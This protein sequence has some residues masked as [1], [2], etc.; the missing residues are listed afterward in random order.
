MSIETHDDP[1][2]TTAGAAKPITQGDSPHATAP[3]WRVGVWAGANVRRMRQAD[4]I[5]LGL[6]IVAF[7]YRLY[8]IAH[9]WPQL[10]SDEAVIG[11]M[12]RHILHGEYPVF[13]WGQNYMGAFQAYFAA[14]FF[15]VFGP[16]AFWLH[17]SVLLL[18]MGF[19]A[20]MYGLA[21][22]AY[23]RVVG[24]VMLLWLTVGPTMGVLRELKA[25]GGYQ[26]ILLFGALTLLG[27]WARLRQP[28]RMPRTRRDWLIALATYV[29]L[30]V[31]MGVGLW[32]DLLILPVLLLAVIALVV[33]RPR[34]VCS[35]LG[36]ALLLAFVIS[37]YPYISF[38]V[39]HPNA[40]YNQL[41]KMNHAP[42][43][44]GPIPPPHNWAMQTG[45]TLEVALP[46]ILGSP[47]VCVKSGNIW[48]DY[49]TTMAT[50]TQTAGGACDLTNMAFSLGALA[51]YVI[52]L[53]PI[54]LAL[55]RWA[56]TQLRLANGAAADGKRHAGD[57][58]LRRWGRLA[59]RATRANLVVAFARDSGEPTAEDHAR[60]ARLARDW[61]RLLLVGVGV[62]N[63]LAYTT[64]VE[65]Q[66]FQFT[67]A[68]YLLLVYL[69]AP[70][71]IGVL[72]GGA[73]P[74]ARWLAGWPQS[75][76]KSD[77][78]TRLSALPVL[79]RAHHNGR[80]SAWRMAWT[81]VAAV[82]LATLLALS[83]YGGAQTLAYTSDNAQFHA[84]MPV[85]D[86]QIIA[87]LDAHHI[88]AFYGDYWTCYRLAFE[89]NERAI[90]AVRGGDPPHTLDL[91]ANRY[92]PYVQTLAHTAHPAY[93]YLA[94]GQQDRNFDAYAAAQRL[95]HVGYQRVV[96]DD[97]AVYYYPA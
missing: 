32:S 81:A 23:G 7:G 28:Q 51:L 14:I 65:A 45:E 89:S 96:I 16:S 52:A 86:Q 56:A 27:V 73:L 62:A 37:A 95:P 60:A 74:V 17:F 12:A 21:S 42:G 83:L 24:V 85:E 43:Q 19:L 59:Y 15:A 70:I 69:S 92:A 39:V 90:C 13:F 82:G 33:G 1:V 49:P 80:Q 2:A 61:L 71:F 9:G 93:I 11:L 44:L 57:G 10:D 6:L 50:E 66:T 8:L 46:T 58:R 84:P 88:T 77:A 78:N 22:A 26:D 20:A 55:W 4:W 53:L 79:G 38:N 29:G 67:S 47:Y 54:L 91:T 72:W 75:R 5:A 87:F 36:L 18:T 48:S 68:R 34:E 40:T 64:S 3:R 35:W 31:A 94:G 63:I 97:Y 30:G 25:I 41:A 76:G